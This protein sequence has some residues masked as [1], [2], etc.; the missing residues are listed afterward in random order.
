MRLG[1]WMM[2]PSAETLGPLDGL[3][4]ILPAGTL[5][6]TVLCGCGGWPSGHSVPVHE[7]WQGEVAAHQWSCVLRVTPMDDNFT[8]NGPI[9]M[10]ISSVYS[11]HYL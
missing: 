4:V 11:S 1:V 9:P 10:R 8:E 2:G 3:R 7:A 5:L 6:G